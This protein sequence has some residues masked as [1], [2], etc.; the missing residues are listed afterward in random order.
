[1]KKQTKQ[2]P[3]STA[4]AAAAEPLR[5]K[6][7]AIARASFKSAGEPLVE[8]KVHLYLDT[9]GRV[10][11]EI[12]STG[13]QVV[14]DD[15]QLNLKPGATVTFTCEVGAFAIGLVPVEFEGTQIDFRVGSA[16]CF[17]SSRPSIQIKV[18]DTAADGVYKWTLTVFF[19]PKWS[20]K[21]K[22]KLGHAVTIDPVLRVY[23]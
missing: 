13:A 3:T 16:A 11:Y 7:Q 10:V 1:M 21:F 15:S 20:K 22:K 17:E 6:A 5:K 19:D 23:S 2:K 8:A 14:G 12:N 18:P 4:K 9:M